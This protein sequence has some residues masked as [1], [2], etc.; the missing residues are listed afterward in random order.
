[1][2]WT[3]N[4]ML[5]MLTPR[6][7]DSGEDVGGARAADDESGTLIDHPIPDGA[8]LVVARVGGRDDLTPDAHAT[9]LHR[10]L[11]EDRSDRRFLLSSSVGRPRMTSKLL[12]AA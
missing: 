9:F 7:L 2:P 4:G 5:E 6:E 12:I 10:R 3:Q 8:P 1:M 11:A